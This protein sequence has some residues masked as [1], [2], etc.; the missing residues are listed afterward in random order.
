VIII[1]KPAKN[2]YTHNGHVY[3]WQVIK[4]TNKV[5]TRI[6]RFKSQADKFA[7]NLA[8]HYGVMHRSYKQTGEYVDDKSFIEG[9]IDHWRAK[10]KRKRKRVELKRNRLKG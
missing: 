8:K 1:T 3:R 7:K 6:F 5:A 10:L 4:S 9:S 2:Y